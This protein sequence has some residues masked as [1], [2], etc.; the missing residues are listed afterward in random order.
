MSRI[1]LGSFFIIFGTLY[2][3]VNMGIIRPFLAEEYLHLSGKYWPSLLVFWGLIIISAKKNPRL[4]EALRWLALLLVGIWLFC[5][6][7]F[8]S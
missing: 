5:F 6:I 7:C 2:L 4:A 1:Y 8:F 3:L